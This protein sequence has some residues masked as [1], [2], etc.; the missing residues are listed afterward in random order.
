MWEVTLLR[1][2]CEG[3]TFSLLKSFGGFDSLLPGSWTWQCTSTSNIETTG[4]SAFFFFLRFFFLKPLLLTDFWRELCNVNER[5]LEAKNY[6]LNIFDL[7][8][9]STLVFCST[10]MFVYIWLYH[11]CIVAL[12]LSEKLLQQVPVFA[13]ALLLLKILIKFWNCL[14]FFG[15]ISYLWFPVKFSAIPLYLLPLLK[16]KALSCLLSPLPTLMPDHFWHS[17]LFL[18]QLNYADNIFLQES[19]FLLE[20]YKCAIQI[21]ALPES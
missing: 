3:S 17:F 4:T 13:V 21:L 7:L 20:V 14:S 9:F 6:N 16:S 12:V 15:E 5:E 19:C 11:P 2:D 8:I 18:M 10:N 1:E